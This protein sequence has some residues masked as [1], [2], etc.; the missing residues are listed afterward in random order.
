M[1]RRDFLALSSAALASGVLSRS[2]SAQG[3]N[4]PTRPVKLII[5]YAP[6]GASDIIGRPWADVLSQSFG[7]QFVIENRGGA[8]GSIGVEAALEGRARRIHVP[9]DAVGGDLG[10]AALAAD[11]LRCAKELR[12]GRPRRRQRQRLRDPSFARPEDDEGDGRVCEE[13]PGQ[14]CLWVLGPG[15]DPA[16]AHRDA[17]ISRRNRCAARAVSRRWRCAERSSSRARSR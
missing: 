7:Q 6:G 14:A 9:D 8:A 15:H 12:S 10:A 3:A 17:E 5:P 13:E 16:H 4:W 1:R 11:A 2:A